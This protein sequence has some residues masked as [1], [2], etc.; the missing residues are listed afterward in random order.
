MTSTKRFTALI[1][2]VLGLLPAARAQL[3]FD[4]AAWDFGSIG[5]SAGTVS[6]TFTGVNRGQRP[7]VIL[8]V[9]TTCGCTVPEFS[10]KPVLPGDSTRIRVTFD[11]TNRPGSF[12]KE[13]GVYSQERKKIAAL[14]VQGQVTPRERSLEELYPV[15]AG[16]GLRLSSTL[17]AFTYLYPGREVHAAVGYAN[18][19]DRPLRLSLVPRRESGLLRTDYPATIAPGERGEIDLGYL[20]PAEKP[21]YGTVNDAL[22]IVVDGHPTGTLLTAHG[23]GVDN[24]RGSEQQKAPRMEISENMI[25]FGAV[26]HA[27][28]LQRRVLTIANRGGSELVVRAVENDGHVATTLAPGERIAPGETLTTE[29]LLDPAAQTFG[30]MTDRLLLVTNDPVRPMRRLRVTAIIED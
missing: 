26:K 20:I 3:V 15:E 29:V 17:S 22:E 23:I 6:H 14:T 27:G 24:P 2:C 16:R 1:I 9:V 8:D 4:P 21:R 25:K 18:T 13:L 7:V 19:S 10:R 28:P 12:R 30:V 11:P 5:E